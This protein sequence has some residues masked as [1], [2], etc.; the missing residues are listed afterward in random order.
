MKKDIWNF[1]HGISEDLKTFL[2][3]FN[4]FFSGE[5]GLTTKLTCRY[6][7]QWNSGQVER[8]VR[9]K[10]HHIIVFQNYV[11]C[12]QNCASSNVKSIID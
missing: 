4:Y 5:F 9:Q 12:P 11:L 8:F 1:D 6:G 10:S 2:K 3:M 7:A